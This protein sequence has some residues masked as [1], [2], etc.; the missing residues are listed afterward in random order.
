[1]HTCWNYAVAGTGGIELAPVLQLAAAVV[2]EDV[3]GA[4][5]PV[6]ARHLLRLVIQVRELEACIMVT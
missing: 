1:M 2:E 6:F 4:N 3:G 5:R